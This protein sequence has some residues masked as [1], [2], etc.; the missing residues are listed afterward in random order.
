MHFV[1]SRR[2]GEVPV[3]RAQWNSLAAE[4]AGAT[5][6]QTHEWFAAWWAAFARR[7]QLFLITAWDGADLAGI[8]P[9]MVERHR[10]VRYLEFVGSPNADYQDLILG[11]RPEAVLAGLAEFL[12]SHRSHWDMLV[13]RNL[14]TDSVTYRLLPG[15]LN[16]LGIRT[17]DEERIPC[18]TLEIASRP[19]ETRRR[20]N[21]YSFRRRI[22]R[23][24]QAGE[25]GY[26]RCS[27]EEQLQRYL[28]VF[29]EQYIERRA[30]S[31]AESF[32][33]RP[34]VREFYTSL[35]HSMLPHGWLH[36]SVLECDG[37]PVAFH[38][39]FEFKK[40]LYWYKPSYDPAVA[41]L[42]PGKV[43]LSHLIRDAMERELEE[44]DF[45][46]GA[47]PFKYRYTRTERTNVTLRAFSRPWMHRTFRRLSWA[48]RVVSRWRNR[49]RQ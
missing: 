27:T 39:G 30:G 38:F 17:T 37:R 46:V 16:D 32:F 3:D 12:A 34:E 4:S 42:S 5:I 6:F 1:L 28:P 7:R 23:L 22:N 41:R 11:P 49:H 24:R 8:A 20:L 18:P 21:G 44:L 13:L 25:T 35:A 31:P 47:E 2:I 10:G 43:L 48:R 45:T 36:F 14:P 15:M 26:V 29:F 40:R 19:E 9:L 33:R